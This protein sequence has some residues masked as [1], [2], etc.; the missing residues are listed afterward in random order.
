MIR[1]ISFSDVF[2]LTSDVQEYVD[3]SFTEEEL[4]AEFNG[5]TRIQKHSDLSRSFKTMCDKLKV[6]LAGNVEIGDNSVTI[7]KEAV[8]SYMDGVRQ[9]LHQF[10]SPDTTIETFINDFNML[11]NMMNNSSDT[12]WVY[13]GIPMG[14][15]EFMSIL[16]FQ[17]YQYKRDKIT[18]R[19]LQGFN[20]EG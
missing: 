1:F 20:R 5:Y 6:E 2:V 4:A 11:K 3:N 14:T 18:L 12:Q 7:T 10:S 16:Y 8:E 9:A 17:M 15:G 13:T 19:L